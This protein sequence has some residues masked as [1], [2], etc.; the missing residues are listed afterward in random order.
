MITGFEE[1]GPGRLEAV[2][3]AEAID[4]R[5]NAAGQVRFGFPGKGLW[6]KLN[7]I[8]SGPARKGVV[9]VTPALRTEIQILWPVQAWL[10]PRW[11]NPVGGV[12][13]AYPSR[14]MV[15]RA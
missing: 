9:P 11:C 12:T 13:T 5:L 4:G 8:R 7:A 2:Y 3:V 15:L 14:S 6:D 10:D 1:L